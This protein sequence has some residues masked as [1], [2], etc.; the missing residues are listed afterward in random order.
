MKIRWLVYICIYIY[1]GYMYIYLKSR[2][3][4]KG[5]YRFVSSNARVPWHV[6]S[7]SK[8]KE[9]EILAHSS[10]LETCCVG[11]WDLIGSKH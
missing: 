2:K 11:Q 7:R 9:T 10:L 3:V 4:M 8:E 1:R 5:I 6:I